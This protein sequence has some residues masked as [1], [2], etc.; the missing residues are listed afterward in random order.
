MSRFVAANHEWINAEYE[1]LAQ[2]IN[3]YNPNLF[4]AYLPAERMEPDDIDTPPYAILDMRLGGKPVMFATHADTTIDI[5]E[6]LF[7]SDMTRGDVLQR[8]DNRNRAAELLRLAEIKEQMDEAND[9]ALHL[10]KTKK[11]FINFVRPNGDKVLLDDQLRAL[12]YRR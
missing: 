9:L 7:N 1:R 6:R 2:V 8:L 3:D 4:L 10:V 12:R 11:N 5:L